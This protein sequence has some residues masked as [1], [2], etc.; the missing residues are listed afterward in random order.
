MVVKSAA[1]FDL[2]VRI[3]KS[4]SR[5]HTSNDNPCSYS[6]FRTMK[7]RPEVPERPGSIEHARRIVCALVDWRNEEHDHVDPALLHLVDV[8]NGRAAAIVTARRRVLD[9]AQAR[10]PERFVRGRPIQKSPPTAWS[11][12][13]PASSLD[14]SD[15]VAVG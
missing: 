6:D 7:Y 2:D 3:A 11:T 14:Q 1:Q 12:P 13:R 5:P 9:D 10:H 8:H 4:H 15:Q